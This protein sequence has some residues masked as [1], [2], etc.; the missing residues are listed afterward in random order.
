M[1][2]KEITIYT[3]NPQVTAEELSAAGCDE[4]VISDPKD[5]EILEKESWGYTGSFVDRCFIDGLKK[6]SSVTFYIGENEDL[7]DELRAVIKKSSVKAAIVDDEDWLHKWEEYYVPF[8]IT[9]GIM[10]KPVFR[11][12]EQKGGETVIEIDPGMAFGTG[13]SPT[14]YLAAQ[15]LAKYMKPGFD[16]LD[17]GCGTGI[18]SLI[19]AKLGAKDILAVD[20]DPEA[21][22]STKTNAALNNVNNIQIKR[23]DLAKGL[24]FKADLIAANLTGPLILE[25][26]KNIKHVC[27]PGT[28]LIASGI[29]EEM[30]APCSRAI[31][32]A[33]F[34]ILKIKRGDCWSAIAAS[35]KS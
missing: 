25:L 8:E 33:G 28:I 31:E 27:R 11:D 13:S 3:E 10:I 16:V 22:S 2:Y 30:E 24:E 18:Q 1:K 6:K 9:E 26:C 20:Y 32:D 35:F 21:V 5:L 34:E 17:I 19:A 14:T 4:L 29:I 12:Y 23:N 15:L 7:T